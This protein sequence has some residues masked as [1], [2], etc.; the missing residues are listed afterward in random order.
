MVTEVNGATIA[1]GGVI[2]LPSGA[3]LTINS[4]GSYIYNPNNQFEDLQLGETTT[5]SFTYTIDD[6]NGGTSEATVAIT[7]LGVNDNPI[8]ENN[9]ETLNADQVLSDNMITDVDSVDGADSDPEGDMLVVTSINGTTLIDG[10]TI[11]VS[12]THLTLP[13]KA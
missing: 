6:G 8:A 12:Y 2:P 5:D 4:D 9:A 11:T 10:S 1:S 3:L 13:T 7:I